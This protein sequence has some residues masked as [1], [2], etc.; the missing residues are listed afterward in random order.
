MNPNKNV[1]NKRYKSIHS[2]INCKPKFELNMNDNNNK[3]PHKKSMDLEPYFLKEA[4]NNILQFSHKVVLEPI[5]KSKDFIK[6]DVINSPSSLVKK[7][8][9]ENMN[10]KSNKKKNNKFRYNVKI[11][12]NASKK[13]NLNCEEKAVKPKSIPR[14]EFSLNLEIEE[15]KNNDYIYDDNRI[16]I[17]YN[18]SNINYCYSSATQKGL[19][20]NRSKEKENNQDISLILEEVCGIKN[21]INK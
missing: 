18:S 11:N 17:I 1:V 10:S 15:K 12:S 21:Y 13:Y 8:K 14:N 3:F 4:K 6:N 19:L 5:R 20:I 7:E 2:Q 9:K 16:Q